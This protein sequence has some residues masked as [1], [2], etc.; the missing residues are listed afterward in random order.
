MNVSS[1]LMSPQVL[2]IIITAH[3][4]YVAD[5]Y[6]VYVQPYTYQKE[7]APPWYVVDFVRATK[8]AITG[9]NSVK[10][11]TE[12]CLSFELQDK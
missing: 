8:S 2:T 7:V 4:A 11:D 3:H 10:V 9:Y 12:L 1:G 6:I 5:S